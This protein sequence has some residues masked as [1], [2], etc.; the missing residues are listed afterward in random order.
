MF[1]AKII[2]GRKDPIITEVCNFE[3]R[4][5][6]RG[7]LAKYPRQP[8]A[9]LTRTGAAALSQTPAGAVASAKCVLEQEQMRLEKIAVRAKLKCFVRP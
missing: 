3:W 9:R 2:R 4:Q 8:W 1:L 7:Q 6:E 5:N